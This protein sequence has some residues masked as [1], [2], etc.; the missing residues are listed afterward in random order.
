[1]GFE[2]VHGHGQR[3]ARRHPQS[4]QR[5]RREAVATGRSGRSSAAATP[6]R[7][8]RGINH[9]S[10]LFD[11]DGLLVGSS[12][13]KWSSFFFLLILLDVFGT[14]QVNQLFDEFERRAAM[15][16]TRG[17][18]SARAINDQ[19]TSL[20]VTLEDAERTLTTR[21]TAPLPRD[22]DQLEHM[23]IEHKKFETEL[24]SLQPELEEAK[25]NVESCPRKTSSMQ[26]KCPS[27]PS[28]PLF[29]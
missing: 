7:D 14:L 15:G 2:P 27:L 19:L 22:L 3:A 10:T 18:M 1:M 12:R 20:L 8:R 11:I 26:I 17:K 9:N 28:F 29:N 23:V 16:D 24:Q 21:I 5:R 13:L 4:A 6:A 25:Q